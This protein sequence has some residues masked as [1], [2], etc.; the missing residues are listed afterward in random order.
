MILAFIRI[1]RPHQ[2]L[3]NLLL[4][5]PPFFAGKMTDPQALH[6]VLPVLASFSLAASCMYIINDIR[7]ADVDRNHSV[8]RNR[9]IAHG[10][11][12]VPLALVLAASLYVIAM[13]ISS[14]VSRTF[15]GWLI[16]YLIISFIYTLFFKDLVIVDIFFITAGF[17][18]RVLAGGEAFNIPVTNW[19]FLTVFS[20]SLL[21]AAGK[22]LGELISL[23]DKASKHRKS[24]MHYSPS[25]LEG[26]M[27]F[28]AS[29]A[30]VTYALYT[31]GHKNGLFYT[32]PVAAFGLLRYNYI[33]KQGQGDPTEALIKDG[34]IMLV[35]ILWVAMMG[36]I[37]YT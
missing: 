18:I 1:L 4:L 16:L 5:F 28:S 20:V 7:D 36:I 3:K 8:K 15:Q 2:W 24:L 26:I 25:Y 6:V 35:G 22:R 32:V 17:L 9:G 27:W 31:I 14:S 29:A 34:Q 37:I 11:I 21:L 19:L 10:D 13:F 12:S 23:G 30:L 33:V